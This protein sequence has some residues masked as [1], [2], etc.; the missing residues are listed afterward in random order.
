MT[1]PLSTTNE[2][3]GVWLCCVVHVYAD[4]TNSTGRPD[5]E[6]GGCPN[7]GGHGLYRSVEK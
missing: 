2:R 1:G 5:D 6:D 3:V 7:C 4:G